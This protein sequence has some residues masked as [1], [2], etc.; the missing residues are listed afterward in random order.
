MDFVQGTPS[1]GSVTKTVKQRT[2]HK[3]LDVPT[4]QHSSSRVKRDPP[5]AGKVHCV[6][7]ISQTRE[8]LGMSDSPKQNPS[9]RLRALVWQTGIVPSHGVRTPD[10]HGEACHQ[11]VHIEVRCGRQLAFAEDTESDD[12]SP[13]ETLRGTAP[14]HSVSARASRSPQG[15][16]AAERAT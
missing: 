3:K 13:P 5:S 10:V 11:L 15:R 12:H 7:E 1:N 4:S 9:V 14:S 6:L 2:G 8:P 16:D